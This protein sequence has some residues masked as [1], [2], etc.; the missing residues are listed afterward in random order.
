LPQTEDGL[1]AGYH[2]H[3]SAEAIAELERLRSR[4]A[5]L[6][7]IPETAFW[8]LEHYA[9]FAEHLGRS[10]PRAVKNEACIIFDLTP[11]A[12]AGYPDYTGLVIRTREL[13]DKSVPADG[14]LAVVSRGDEAL[15]D[16]GGR[17]A[18]HFP[19]DEQGRY[20]GYHPA[21]SEQA[22]AHLRRLQRRGA[23]HLVIPATSFWWLDHYGGLCRHLEENADV[24]ARREDTGVVFALRGK[25][26]RRLFRILRRRP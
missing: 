9:E 22:I 12:P 21:D 1:Y 18:W 8:W 26:R 7:L 6:L 14:C 13:V 16:L 5:E 17:R 4:G 24:V 15:L 20:A 11:D 23:D 3:D 19:Q 10:Y 2:P 25:E